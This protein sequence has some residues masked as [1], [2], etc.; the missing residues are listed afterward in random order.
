MGKTIM[1][2]DREEVGMVMR[3]LASHPD[4]GALVSATASWADRL[5][6]AS[7]ERSSAHGTHVVADAVF[8][9]DQFV[10]ALQRSHAVG[11]EDQAEALRAV[12]HEVHCLAEIR[13]LANRREPDVYWSALRS[14]TLSV[15][16]HPG[17][18]PD[19]ADGKVESIRRLG[20]TRDVES[21]GLAAYG[22]TCGF[23]HA[24]EIEE[25][26]ASTIRCA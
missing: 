21:Y 24:R 8:I 7:P 2:A 12:E 20:N 14:G 13:G 26:I 9:C 19:I 22:M 17:A 1:P 3:A 23:N 4:L 11:C 18:W 6:M 5:P 15:L 10:L 16:C 25:A